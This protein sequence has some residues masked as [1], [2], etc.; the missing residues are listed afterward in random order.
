MYLATL[1]Q[2]DFFKTCP[3]SKSKKAYAA[4]EATFVC[5][6]AFFRRIFEWLLTGQKFDDG[7]E[8]EL[9]KFV[10]SQPRAPWLSCKECL[11]Q[12]M[13]LHVLAQVSHECW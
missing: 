7:R 6:E 11:R 4:Q 3:H 2:P 13:S 12:L 8:E 5:R 9:I 1:N 10:T